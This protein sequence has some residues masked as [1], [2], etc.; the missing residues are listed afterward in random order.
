[1]DRSNAVA[2]LAG[3]IEGDGIIALSP[4][5]RKDRTLGIMV[6][7]EISITMKAT[8]R[9]R[10]LMEE[11]QS[12][13]GGNINVRKYRS[14]F[15][16]REENRVEWELISQRG[17]KNLLQELIPHLR[18]KRR[19]AELL[20]EAIS[21]LLSKPNGISYPKEVIERLA[22]ISIEISRLNAETSER[23]IPMLK[24]RLKLLEELPERIA[25]TMEVEKRCFHS[26]KVSAEKETEIIE[27]YKRGHPVKDICED[28]KISN[29]TLFKILRKHSV[30]LRREGQ[31]QGRCCSCIAES[32]RINEHG[33]RRDSA[34]GR[35]HIR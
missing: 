10:A 15:S 28:F 5:R 35:R 24:R 23:P 16:K 17:V 21:L 29:H 1:M 3:L 20:F 2:Y 26:R 31:K 27:A 13:F 19:Q 33:G 30:P 6:R 14:G 18:L 22:E 34:D 25:R 8:E 7:P 9:T 11:L 12:L 32:L 4:Y